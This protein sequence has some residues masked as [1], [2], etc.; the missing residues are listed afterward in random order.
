MIKKLSTFPGYTVDLQLPEFRKTEPDK[1]PE[2]I[3]L[4][5]D[6]V[7]VCF[8]NLNS[9]DKYPEGLN[10]VTVSDNFSPP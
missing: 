5:S 8:I 3:P 6:Q 7:S 9:E 1:L 4:L 10:K 2:F